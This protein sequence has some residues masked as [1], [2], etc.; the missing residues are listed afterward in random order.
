MPA[1]LALAPLL[2][3]LPAAAQYAG[4]I[5]QLG[6]WIGEERRQKQIPLVAIALVDDQRIVWQHVFGEGSPETVFR[7][8]SVSEPLTNIALMQLVEKGRVDLDAP[9]TRYLP[10]FKPGNPFR[11]EITLRQLMSHRAGLVQEPPIGNSFDEGYT[12]LENTVRS[13]NETELVY[14]PGARTKRSSA[15]IAV[16]GRVVEKLA[17][18]PFAAHIKKSVLEPLGMKNSG[19][20]LESEWVA[21]VTKGWMWSYG[22]RLEAPR[23]DLGMAPAGNLYASNGDLAR[24]LSALFRGGEPV[25]RPP[26]L[27]KMW[28]AQFGSESGLGFWLGRVGGSRSVSQ[29]G[30]IH[31][32]SCHV[33]ALPG[34]KLG[35]VVI[36]N[37]GAATTLAARMAQQALHWMQAARR[38]EQIEAPAAT[39]AGPQEETPMG[40]P[41][42]APLAW[43]GYL[44][45]FGWD[46]G[47]LYVLERHGRL[48]ALLE[49]RNYIPLEPVKEAVFRLPDHGPFV[50]ESLIFVSEGVRLGGVLFPKRPAGLQVFRIRPPRP[51][52]QLR[53]QAMAAAPPVES[54]DFLPSE[55]VELA[56]LDRTLHLDI[57]YASRDNF[58]GEPVYREARAFLQRPAAEALL[59]AHQA[60]NKQGYGLLIHDAYRPWYVSK[61]FW[62]AT[63][64]EKRMFVA[65]PSLGSR[66]NRGCAVDLTLYELATG[67]PVEMPSLY[68]EMTERASPDYPGGA[69]LQRWHRGLLRREMERQGFQVYEHEWWHFD[70]R[71]WE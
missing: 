38:G 59:R 41:A 7:V 61:I 30:A 26:T 21:Y 3:A 50:G 12:T 11:R 62:D 39:D 35:A 52:E 37:A 48:T 46:F 8:G 24:F 47:E 1:R 54:G 2:L 17:G 25:M 19:Y 66:H 4:A 56:A 36:L 53:R 28:E 14:E 13:V 58:L 45:E 20:K 70:Y 33:A 23:F 34:D 51:V 63:P 64:P 44:G 67:K 31:G 71:G 42:P 49:G 68:D 18:E 60:L 29:S 55:L 22:H 40:K 16:V 43:L 57:R 10:D 6:K 27:A 32:F 65:D 9:V 69:T 5:Q 15:G